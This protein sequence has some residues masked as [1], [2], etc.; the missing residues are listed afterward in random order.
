MV[1]LPALIFHPIEGLVLSETGAGKNYPD[2][3]DPQLNNTFARKNY[4]KDQELDATTQ[5]IG[6]HIKD[7]VKAVIMGHLHLLAS[8]LQC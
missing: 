4:V 5:K 7:D 8:K 6:N 1:M 3:W 2:V